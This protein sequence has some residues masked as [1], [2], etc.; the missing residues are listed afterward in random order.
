MHISVLTEAHLQ[1]T[2]QLL[3]EGRFFN[4]EILFNHKPCFLGFW[5]KQKLIGV[6]GAETFNQYALLRALVVTKNMR[7]QEIGHALVQHLEKHLK[8][9]GIKQIFLSTKYGANYLSCH[10]Y[11]RISPEK[12]PREIH[13]KLK[14][15]QIIEET[16]ILMTKELA[17]GKKPQVAQQ[18]RAAEISGIRQVLTVAA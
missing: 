3:T 16:P 2:R 10:D 14:L 9:N 12:L 4:T 15:Q 8:G 7:G 5:H 1:K 13:S 6:I 18:Q 17:I 11:C